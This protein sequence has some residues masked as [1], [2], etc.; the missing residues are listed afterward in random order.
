MKDKRKP[1]TERQWRA[2]QIRW[3]RGDIGVYRTRDG[4]VFATIERMDPKIQAEINEILAKKSWWHW[5][6]SWLF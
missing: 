6:K 3:E 5:L 2:Q 4:E 1:L